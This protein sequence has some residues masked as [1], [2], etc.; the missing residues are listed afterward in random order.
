MFNSSNL[1]FLKRFVLLM[2]SAKLP[3]LIET[4]FLD[5]IPLTN[6]PQHDCLSFLIQHVFSSITITTTLEIIALHSTDSR[7]LLSMYLMLINTHKHLI[8]LNQNLIFKELKQ[9]TQH[10]NYLDKLLYLLFN[11]YKF[12]QIDPLI[13]S[14]TLVIP[15]HNSFFFSSTDAIEYLIH[16][17]SCSIHDL[18]DVLLYCDAYMLDK[19]ATIVIAF[20]FK[21][22]TPNSF[23]SILTLLYNYNSHNISLLTSYT[24]FYSHLVVY[25]LLNRHIIELPIDRLITD[26]SIAITALINQ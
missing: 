24:T 15:S 3:A 4:S 7:I 2:N 1:N 26:A 25:W 12:P 8:A 19:Q 14:I 13:D 11:D 18:V 6:P 23:E 20:I 16:L 5:A 10:P 9:T 17:Q 21:K 22:I